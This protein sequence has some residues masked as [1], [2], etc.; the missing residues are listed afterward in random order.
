ML[1]FFLSTALGQQF[2]RATRIFFVVAYSLGR[3]FAGLASSARFP[4][5]ETVKQK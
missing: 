1:T 2:Y 3:P 4:A 5:L